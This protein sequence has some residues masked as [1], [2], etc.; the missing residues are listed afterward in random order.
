MRLRLCC[1]LCCVSGVCFTSIY[2][3]YTSTH[4]SPTRRRDL[5]AGVEG[6]PHNRLPPWPPLPR[7]PCPTLPPT[8]PTPYYFNS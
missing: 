7:P 3:H 2:C 8:A 1:K 6:P 5:P 4:P